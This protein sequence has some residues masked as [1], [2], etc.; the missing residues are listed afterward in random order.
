[1]KKIF[2]L[3]TGGFGI[4]LA[5]TCDMIG[6]QVT[7]WSLF[8]K[9]VQLVRQNRGNEKLLPGITLSDRVD[10]TEDISLCREA[11]VVIVAVP[12][13][14]VR[15]TVRLAAPHIKKDAVIVNV[16][17]GLEIDEK[18]NF[19]RLS[20]VIDQETASKNIVVMTGPTHAEEIAKGVPSTITAASVNQD[21]AVTVQELFIN[22]H[23]RVYYNDDI[24]SAEVGGAVKNCIAL[25]AG[26]IDGM[27]LGDNTKA[28]LM[29]R[30]LAEMAR[31]GVAMGGRQDTFAG[32]SG[33]GDLI[34]T[35]TSVHSRNHRAGELIGKGMTA[36]EAI[37][38]VGMTVE[39]YSAVKTAYQI[40]RKLNVE[41]PI[42]EQ[43]YL[44]LYKDKPTKDALG[45]LM[46]R[47][48]KH[49]MERPWNA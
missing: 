9:E 28:A 19:Y 18:G 20:E 4:A 22:S 3:G 29:T 45:D 47:P 15:S 14:A 36:K 7:M 21:A 24:I 35:C 26:I 30:G 34:V 40:S 43:M 48:Q 32:L 11:D 25:A 23:L 38:A 39:G 44:T 5:A 27:G 49:E 17:K 33:V 6:H 2:I 31:L 37:D 10:I 8:E 46:V 13:F 12:S 16:A 42:I 1:M 41:M